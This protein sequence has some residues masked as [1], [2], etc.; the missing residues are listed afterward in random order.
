MEGEGSAGSLCRPFG[1][2]AYRLRVPGGF[3]EVG[4][5]VQGLIVRFRVQGVEC[6][7]SCETADLQSCANPREVAKRADD[8]V[9]ELGPR[10]ISQKGRLRRGMLS[11][12]LEKRQHP[13]K[14]DPQKRD[15]TLESYAY[16][17]L[18]RGLRGLVF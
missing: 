13:E 15:P 5:G 18:L 16:A 8:M 2:R 10:A 1:F 9:I 14:K 12:L 17:C 6:R 7:V 4:L 11:G 3:K